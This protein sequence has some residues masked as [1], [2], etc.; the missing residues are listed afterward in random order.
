MSQQIN[1]LNPALAPKVQLFKGESVLMALGALLLLCLIASLALGWDTR[2]LA[3]RE[4]EQGARLA[5][6][7][8]DV[9]R[10]GQEVGAR[11]PSR[12]LQNEMAKLDALFAARNEVMAIIGSGALGD[13]RGVSDYFR[14]FARQSLEG[15]WL[16]GFS[17]HNAGAD[18][19]VQGR[20]L[21]ADLV[22]VYLQGL[23]REDALR[24]HGFAAVSVSQPP[25]PV[26]GP[27]GKPQDT[28]FL[29]FRLATSAQDA[30]RDLRDTLKGAG[31]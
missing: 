2:R 3:A 26:A 13:T 20:T 27:D 19:V 9:T 22:P 16:T 5:Q 4:R 15:L 30:E 10:M 11:K 25:R 17:I 12:A 31:R 29:E 8:A 18:I 21:E 7:N 28:R 14:A 6:L 24:G 1:L 23:R